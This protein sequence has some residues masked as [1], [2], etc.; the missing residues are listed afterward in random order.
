MLFRSPAFSFK[1]INFIIGQ[2]LTKSGEFNPYGINLTFVPPRIRIQILDQIIR[3][4]NS[5]II[6][7]SLNQIKSGMKPTRTLPV[8]WEMMQ[9]MLENS[10]FEYC[11]RSY[12]YEA[13]T[14]QPQIISYADWYKLCTFTIPFIKTANLMGIRSVYMQ[15]YLNLTGKKQAPKD[16]KLAERTIKE[17]KSY[18]QLF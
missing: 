11:I 5:E 9:K 3:V 10:G 2:K 15:Y 7:P 12:R 13:F 18:R 4:F 1:P 17:I 16:L 8:N 14:S 6:N